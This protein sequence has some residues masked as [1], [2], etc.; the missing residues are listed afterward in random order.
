MIVALKTLT[1]IVTEIVPE[2]ANSIWDAVHFAVPASDVV[3]MWGWWLLHWRHFLDLFGFCCYR[4]SFQCKLGWASYIIWEYLGR[5]LKNTTFVEIFS[6]KR[7]HLHT[8]GCWKP[9]SVTAVQPDFSPTY[10]S[11]PSRCIGRFQILVMLRMIPRSNW[12]S[13][14]L[15]LD[16]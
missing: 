11:L 16:V 9:H 5:I 8:S 14:A 6:P 13:L 12:C 1:A 3:L 15:F 2:G 10:R 4:Y 7:S